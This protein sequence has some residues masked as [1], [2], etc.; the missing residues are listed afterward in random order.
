M[1]ILM[2][3]IVLFMTTACNST[4][5]VHKKTTSENRD[6]VLRYEIDSIGED[7]YKYA[8]NGKYQKA[9]DTYQKAINRATKEGYIASY[10][11]EQAQLYEKLNK[12]S[13]QSKV[14]EKFSGDKKNLPE[15]WSL[16]QK[17]QKNS[18][19]LKISILQ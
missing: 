17:Q 6:R 15:N 4:P 14:L 10:Y 16:K 12:F 18:H 3:I 5:S 13:E 1:K 8:Q 9:I 11:L 19:I 2:V 7:A